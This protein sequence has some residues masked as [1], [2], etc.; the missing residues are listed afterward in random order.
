MNLD[1]L[2]LDRIALVALIALLVAS[3]VSFA[4]AMRYR[5]RKDEPVVTRSHCES[6]RYPLGAHELIP[7][8]SWLLLRGKCAHCRYPI[9]TNYLQIELCGAVGGALIAWMIVR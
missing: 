9:P 7:V 5:L 3:L 6:C 2:A 4:L 1:M 8:L